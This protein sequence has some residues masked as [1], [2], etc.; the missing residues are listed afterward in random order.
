MGRAWCFANQDLNRLNVIL[1]KTSENDR[2][3]SEFHGTGCI[4]GILMKR[5]SDGSEI[6]GDQSELK[7]SSSRSTSAAV[8]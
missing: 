8:L 6:T 4:E 3:I 2:A 5:K 7:W 1:I